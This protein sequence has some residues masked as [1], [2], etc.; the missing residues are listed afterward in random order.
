MGNG[1]GRKGKVAAAVGGEGCAPAVLVYLKLR[2]AP[3]FKSGYHFL[4]V[5]RP[6][7]DPHLF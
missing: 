1:E 5:P 2:S 7:E 4:P 3:T 6:E